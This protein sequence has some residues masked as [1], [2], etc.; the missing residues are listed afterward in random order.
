LAFSGLGE[1]VSELEF[2]TPKALNNSA[3]GITLGQIRFIHRYAESV[4]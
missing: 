2:F 3:Q 1:D 4:E